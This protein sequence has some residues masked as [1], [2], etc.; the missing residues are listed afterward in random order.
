MEN[1]ILEYNI[2]VYAIKDESFLLRVGQYLYTGTKTKSSL[3][4]PK[5]YF[6]DKYNQLFFNLVYMTRERIGKLPTKKDLDFLIGKLYTDSDDE[7]AS[8]RTLTIDIFN[9][10]EPVDFSLIDDEAKDFVKKVKFL[11]AFMETSA[12]IKNENYD[13]VIEKLTK[14]VQISF[15]R[16]FGV[17]LK[18]WEDVKGI[19]KENNNS[20]LIIPTGFPTLDAPDF[21][22]GGSRGGE[23]YCVS[24]VPGIGKTAFLGN[25]AVNAFL[26]GKK[27]LVVSF[28]TSEERITERLLANLINMSTVEISNKISTTEVDD[29]KVLFDK[30]VSSISGELRIKEYP[31]REKSTNDIRAFL[32]DL[33]KY[34]SFKPDLI[35][36]DYILIMTP[37]NKNGFEEANSYLRYKAVAEEMRNLGISLGIPVWTASQ[38]G[39]NGQA[40]NGGTKEIT[41]SKDGSESRGILDTVDLYVTLNQTLAH[42]KRGEMSLFIDKNRNGTS[43]KTIPLLIDYSNMRITERP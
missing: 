7:K 17:N 10:T 30:N 31:A 22:K 25:I 40:E 16:D 28:E 8:L 37:N 19:I 1:S 38:I 2:L 6:S 43:G 35:I 5:C 42:R 23:L 29:M 3:K 41:T 34:V 4:N 36:L 33:E 32:M 27:V 9:E 26:Q 39:R 20:S 12:D 21:L 14:S 15:D 11:E 24:A 13:S 18:D